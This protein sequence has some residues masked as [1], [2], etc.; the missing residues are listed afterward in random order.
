MSGIGT[1]NVSQQVIYQIVWLLAPDLP[2]G[3]LVP[4]RPTRGVLVPDLPTGILVAGRPTGGI[5][6]RPTRY[7][8]LELGV[9]IVYVRQVQDPRV[10]MVRISW[11]G[12]CWCTILL[13][14][15]GRQVAVCW[16]EIKEKKENIWCQWWV[17]RVSRAH[18][19]THY[20]AAT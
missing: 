6:P 18:L 1:P 2:T 20:E 13:Q 3:I 16:S 4:D 9:K 15:T 19:I 5:G 12:L 14:Q 8:T 17:G 7:N 10:S 11:L